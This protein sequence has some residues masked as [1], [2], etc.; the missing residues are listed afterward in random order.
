MTYLFIPIGLTAVFIIYMLYIILFKEEKSK[1]KAI[2]YPG[3]LF[4]VIWIII[5]YFLIR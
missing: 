5:Y 4:I 1:L 3:L 2:A